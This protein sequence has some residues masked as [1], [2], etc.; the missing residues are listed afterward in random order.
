MFGDCCGWCDHVRVVPDRVAW[1]QLPL[2]ALGIRPFIC[3]HCFTRSYRF[4]NWRRQS[5]KVS[6]V[7]KR[8]R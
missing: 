4:G 7:A 3:P 6:A 5:A 1:Y 8:H 2:L